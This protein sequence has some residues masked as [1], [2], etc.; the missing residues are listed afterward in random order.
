MVQVTPLA[1]V[2]PNA[3]PGVYDTVNYA[4]GTAS[5]GTQNNAVLIIASSGGFNLTN[6]SYVATGFQANTIYGPNGPSQVPLQSVQDSINLFGDGYAA[7]TMFTAYVTANPGGNPVYVVTYAQGSGTTSSITYTLSGTITS[8]GQFNLAVPVVPLNYVPVTV[9]WNSNST[10]ASI[11]Q[12]AAAAVNANTHLPIVATSTSTTFT[13]TSKG[14]GLRQ[15]WLRAGVQIVTPG[16]GLLVNGNALYTGQAFFTGGTG[17]D[18]TQVQAAVNAVIASGLTFFTVVSEASCDG[19]DGTINGIPQYIDSSLIDY[20][21]QPV[22]GIRQRYFPGGSVDTLSNTAAVT[23][24]MN[25]P[26]ALNLAWSQNNNVPP[27]LLQTYLCALVNQ[28]EVPFLSPDG[29]NFDGMLLP[30]IP[31]PFDGTA[32]SFVQL[33]I[34]ETS[35][36]SPVKVLKGGQTCLDKAVTTHFWT[37]TNATFDPRIVDSGKVTICEYLVTDVKARC[38]TFMQN[39]K[40]VQDDP[41]AGSA[42]VVGANIATPNKLAIVVTEVINKYA[43]AGLID[44]PSTLAGLVVTRSQTVPSQ[45]Q[46]EIPTYTS[47]LLHTIQL[48]VNQVQ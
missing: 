43:V 12:S 31:A 48:T 33:E 14:T 45:L 41:P 40:L 21:A 35:G 18:L 16:T 34:A 22:I 46:V 3:P 10:I 38:A 29:V 15:N 39:C 44:G 36:I 25:D 5:S 27:Y 32:P 13:L 2:G 20:L 30:G 8:A 47:D 9:T 11:C 37:G 28:R 1:G 23:I 7:S 17:S 26:L 6:G 42:V 24:T 4:A 19:Y